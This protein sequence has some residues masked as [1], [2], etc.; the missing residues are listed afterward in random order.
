M[1]N[2]II[3]DQ[4]Y[5]FIILK[6]YTLFLFVPNIPMWASLSLAFLRLGMG[7]GVLGLPPPRP[8]SLMGCTRCSRHRSKRNFRLS[9][10]GLSSQRSTPTE[11]VHHH[12][13]YSRPYF[14]SRFVHLQHLRCNWDNPDHLR[15]HSVHSPTPFVQ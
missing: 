10:S 7:L 6:N 4:L 9:P 14:R 1:T 2:V 11:L 15:P 8:R 3:L 5:D 13:L 12:H